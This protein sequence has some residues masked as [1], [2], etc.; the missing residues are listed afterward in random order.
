MFDCHCYHIYI[1]DPEF[2][3]MA[4]KNSKNSGPALALRILMFPVAWGPYYMM[5]A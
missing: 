3:V 4:P 5:R 2:L 1:N